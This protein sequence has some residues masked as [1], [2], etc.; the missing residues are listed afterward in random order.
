MEQKNTAN[1]YNCI[2]KIRRVAER[3]NQQSDEDSSEMGVLTMVVQPC[4][5]NKQRVR[6]TDISRNLFIT[7]PAATQCVNRLVSKGW[8]TRVNDPD[9]RR[10]VYI[11]ATESGTAQIERH[12]RERI[13]LLERV[14]Q[15]LGTEKTER[16]AIL[17][18][19]FL[20]ELI[21]QM[22]DKQC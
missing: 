22:E 8:V 19:E 15:S 13:E 16:L 14:S 11:E 10:V 21:T 18:N 3:L 2:S 12:T 9:D 20:D 17:F 6:M 7:K 4:N 1:L 5:E